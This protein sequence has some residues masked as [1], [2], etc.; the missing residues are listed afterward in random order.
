MSERF[1]VH[2]RVDLFNIFN[3]PNFANPDS[4]IGDGTFGQSIGMAN[5]GLGGAG[6]AGTTSLN[7]VFQA[8]G[9][10]TVQMSL[11]LQF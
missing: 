3:H 4:T 7:S 1:R 6:A 10:R 8:G 9:P 11:K 2:F 5:G